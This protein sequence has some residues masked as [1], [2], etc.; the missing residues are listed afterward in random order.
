[1]CCLILGIYPFGDPNRS[2]LDFQDDP[3]QTTPVHVSGAEKFFFVEE[4]LNRMAEGRMPNCGVRI[5]WER[6]TSSCTE[7]YLDNYDDLSYITVSSNVAVEDFPTRVFVDYAEEEASQGCFR[8]FG[9][10]DGLMCSLFP[11][12]CL[13]SYLCPEVHK[14]EVILV[15]GCIRVGQHASANNGFRYVGELG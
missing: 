3:T 2:F 12:C 6:A 13:V 1:M 11:E 4:Y 15:T 14:D 9:A 5:S 10:H 7:F 8:L